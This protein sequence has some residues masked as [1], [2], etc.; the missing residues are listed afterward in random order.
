MINLD[1]FI[2]GVIAAVIASLFSGLG[3]ALLFCRKHYS[4]K[5]IN[6]LLNSSAGIMLSSALFNLLNPA[7]VG[8]KSFASSNFYS[9]NIIFL[10]L[11]CGVGVIFI[12]H[13]ILPHQHEH[14]LKYNPDSIIN[15][16]S[17]LLF[18]F[19]I[20][21][22]KLPEG[23]AIG[24]AYAGQEYLNPMSLVIGMSLQ[25][26]PEG[27]MVSTSLYAIKFSRQRAV[28]YAALT[29]LLQ[30]LGAILGLFMTSFSDILIP[31]GMALAGGTMFFVV[32]N[33]V[34]PETCYHDNKDKGAI[35]LVIGFILMTY[36]SI[37]VG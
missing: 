14:E 23:L 6:I 28:Y 30:P 32:V 19:A 15:N 12:I 17:A 34:I 37:I 8:I 35:S 29:G 18:V 10:A 22:H 2:Y 26:I 1:V 27:L 3:G 31:F 24:V 4:N 36:I 9:A 16:R 21:L 7:V 25:N 33:E 20:A 13:N 11:L 5:S